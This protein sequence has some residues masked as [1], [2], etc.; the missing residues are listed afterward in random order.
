MPTVQISEST[1]RVVPLPQVC[2]KTGTP[3]ADVLT[4]TGSAAPLWTGVLIV[5]GFLPWLVAS[6]ASSKRYAIEVPMHA[7]VWR[8]HRSLRRAALILVVAGITLVLVASIQGR[9]NAWLLLLPTFIG[10]ALY[11]GNESMNTVGVH[12]SGDGGLLLTRVHPEFR[13]ALLDADHG[14]QPR[15]RLRP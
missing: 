7:A 4:I 11:V 8:R 10:V 15:G 9:D 5:F 1:M 2:V 12:L 3:T 13:R 14:T 6:L